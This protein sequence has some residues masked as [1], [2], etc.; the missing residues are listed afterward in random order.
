MLRPGTSKFAPVRGEAD[1]AHHSAVISHARASGACAGG[2]KA[3]CTAS[4]RELLSSSRR[5]TVDYCRNIAITLADQVAGF[6]L[7]S[8]HLN[9]LNLRRP[10]ASDSDPP[11]LRP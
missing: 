7:N 10:A 8:H 1:A 2:C 9:T 11:E 3:R 4:K 5:D 6:G